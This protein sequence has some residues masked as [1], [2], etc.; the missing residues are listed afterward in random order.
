MLEPN[1]DVYEEVLKP[2]LEKFKPHLEP[3]FPSQPFPN[4]HSKKK[5]KSISIVSKL[6]VVI[7]DF[8]FHSY[9]TSHFKL[10]LYVLC[11][12]IQFNH[13]WFVPF[14]ALKNFFPSLLPNNYLVADAKDIARHM[15]SL[16]SP[17]SFKN[18]RSYDHAI[19]NLSDDEAT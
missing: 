10:M 15:A 14:Y 17:N 7:I 16:P 3:N 1:N 4:S 9:S 12:N 8:V 5:F 11:R 2:L 19:L 6:I 18:K 13:Y